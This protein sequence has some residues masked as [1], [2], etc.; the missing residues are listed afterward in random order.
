MRTI[1]NIF[2]RSPFSSL[3][4]HME[5][6]AFCVQSLK[7]LFNAIYEEKYD[8]ARQIASQIQHREHE[9]DLTKND[10]RNHLPKTLFLPIDRGQLLEILSMQDSLADRAEDVS[11][12]CTIKD[13]KPISACKTH[14]SKF[15]EKNLECFEEI[16]KIIEELHDLLESSFGGIEAEKVR[17]MVQKVAFSEHEADVIQKDL[18]KEIFNVEKELSLSEFYLWLKIF[19]TVGEIS[20][21]SEALANRIRM[22]LEHK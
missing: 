22:T 4:K 19:E 14:F 3:R 20:N 9:A 1:V 10:I 7:E 21:I 11:V 6:V 17:A 13:L 2:G 15:L 12:L 18:L 8:S 5:H 16:Q